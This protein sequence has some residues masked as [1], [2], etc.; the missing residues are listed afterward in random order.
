MKFSLNLNI[1]QL[2]QPNIRRVKT[3]DFETYI[4]SLSEVVEKYSYNRAIGLDV[5]TEGV[6]ELGDMGMKATTSAKDRKRLN[7]KAGALS[8][9]PSAFFDES[10]K[11][12]LYNFI[13]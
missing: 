7:K 12:Y 5:V 10:F 9:V 1:P 11:Y 4:K 13:V 3:T 6:P 8:E 2:L